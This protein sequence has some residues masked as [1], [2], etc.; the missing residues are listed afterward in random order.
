MRISASFHHD[1]RRDSLSS[2]TARETIRKISFKPTSRGSSHPP[3]GR[4]RLPAQIPDAAPNRRRD[5]VHLP[6]WHR[7]S[8]LS[9]AEGLRGLRARFRRPVRWRWLAVL[10]IPPAGILAVLGGLSLTVSPRFTPGFFVFGIAAGMV[11]GFCEELGWT[12]FAY[13][14]MQARFGWL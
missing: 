7:F 1:S 8:A 5:E 13:P 14:R 10:L 6:R 2:D 3:P 4:H 12:G 11:A 9:G